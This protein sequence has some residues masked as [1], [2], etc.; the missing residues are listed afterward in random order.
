MSQNQASIG[1]ITGLRREAECLS[2]RAVWL[3]EVAQHDQV[4]PVIVAS[5]GGR[6]A[7]VRQAVRQMAHLGCKGIV[8]FGIAAGLDRVAVPGDLVLGATVELPTGDLL[9]SNGPWRTQLRHMLKIDKI[10]AAQGPILGVDEVITSSLG[11]IRLHAISAAIAAD[12]ESHVVALEAKNAQLPFLVVRA[13]ADP[14]DRAIPSAAY[15]ALGADGRPLIGRVLRR[16]LVRPHQLPGL[17]GV[18]RDTSKAM[19]ALKTV[20]SLDGGRFGFLS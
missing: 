5:V 2:P 10:P 9:K 15:D 3:D 16:L 4:P 14:F 6:A 11:K 12:M 19:K 1:I 20:G 18:A 13:V 17:I 7:G 8:S